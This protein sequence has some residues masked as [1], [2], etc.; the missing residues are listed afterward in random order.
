M[1]I[2]LFVE[3]TRC[4]DYAATSERI[5]RLGLDDLLTLARRRQQAGMQQSMS[6]PLSNLQIFVISVTVEAIKIGSSIIIR[7]ER[8]QFLA[9]CFATNCYPSRF[10]WAS[11]QDCLGSCSRET[12]HKPHRHSP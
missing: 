3:E 9:P 4:A 6:F 10:R 8:P 5:S 2:L 1:K 11:I 12:R 7:S